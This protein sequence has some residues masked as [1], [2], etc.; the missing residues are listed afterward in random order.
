VANKSSQAG[1]VLPGNAALSRAMTDIVP[2]F[3]PD[4]ETVTEIEIPAS[5]HHIPA[6]ER[7]RHTRQRQ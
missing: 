3:Q 2:G 5:G 6:I 7:R 4:L 1:G